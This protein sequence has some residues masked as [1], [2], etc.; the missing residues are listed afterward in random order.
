M[1]KKIQKILEDT[2]AL[3]KGHFKLS[4]GLHSQ[5]YLQC[6]LVLQHPEYAET[7]GQELA[8][9]VRY[10]IKGRKVNAV[11]SPALGGVI[12]GHEVARALKVKAIF[13]ERVEGKFT[14]RRG[15]DIMPGEKMLVV[16]DVVTTGGSSKEIGELVESRGGQVVAYAAICDRSGEAIDFGQALLKQKA[17]EMGIDYKISPKRISENRLKKPFASLWKFNFKNYQPEECPLCQKKIPIYAPGS[18]Y[19]K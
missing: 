13:A 14:L 7:L 17:K 1:D 18:R 19:N 9:K 2:G 6:A 3:K 8:E 10:K 16:E 12:I 4:S 5:F 15:F 11:I